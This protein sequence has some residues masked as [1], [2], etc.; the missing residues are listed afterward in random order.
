M[1]LSWHQ[2]VCLYRACL[3][4]YCLQ[5]SPHLCTFSQAVFPNVGV[6]A[7]TIIRADNTTDRKTVVSESVYIVRHT[8][9]YFAPPLENNRRWPLP[10]YA[11]V[12]GGHQRPC[13]EWRHE[14]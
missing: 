2:I 3:S 11:Y 13:A 14:I 8:S 5:V 10:T 7:I 1:F 9:L 6:A 12:G 4:S